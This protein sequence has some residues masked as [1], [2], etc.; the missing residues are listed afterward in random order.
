MAPSLLAVGRIARA[1]GIRGRVLLAPYNHASEGLERASALWLRRAEEEPRRHEV[2]H[3]ER[4]NLG[5]LVTL[6]GVA[7]RNGADLLRG[8][9]VL[10]DRAEL[11]ELQSDEIWAQDMVGMRLADQGG[12]ER[13]EIV[14]IE[15]A[16]PNDLLQVMTAAGLVLV[17]MGLVR[18][19]D[20]ESKR[21]VIESPEGLFDAQ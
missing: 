7:D 6:Q 10:I 16:G 18:E 14:G 21:V 19:I 13:G 20:E 1:H 8:L 4:V 12:Q 15:S 11:P 2:T 9:E 3:S 5:Y 17:P